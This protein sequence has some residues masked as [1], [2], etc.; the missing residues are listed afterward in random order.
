M[1]TSA[2]YSEFG[3]PLHV[4]PATRPRTLQNFPMQAN[5]AEKMRLAA[6]AATETGLDVGCP[7]HDGFV[8]CA[9]AGRIEADVA[10]MRE[11]MRQA[12][13]AFTRGLEVRVDCQIVRHPHRY[14]DK[15]G[16][17]MWNRI[18]GLRDALGR[19]AA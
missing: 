10:V 4:T 13:L 5:G 8:L 19:I 17:D 2:T 15:R 3:W 16:I 14:C 11:C 6:I 12:T 1:L 18:L 7:V 9:P